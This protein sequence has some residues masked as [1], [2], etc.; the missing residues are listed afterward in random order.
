MMD[1]CSAMYETTDSLADW[2]TEKAPVAALPTE[3]VMAFFF[4]DPGRVGFEILYQFGKRDL[5]AAANLKGV[6][7]QTPQ[8][9]R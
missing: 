6:A 1:S 9:S 8:G 7:L 5:S 2:L 4:Y 3:T